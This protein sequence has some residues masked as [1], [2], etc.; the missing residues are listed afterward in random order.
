MRLILLALVV[1]AFPTFANSNTESIAEEEMSAKAWLESM[2]QALQTKQYK[3]SIIQLQADHIRPLVYL[4]GTVNNKEVA[5][6]EYLNGPPKNAVRVADT[7]TFIEHD[8]PA[9]SITAPRIQGVWP[10]IFATDLSSLEEG[11]QFILGGRSR[12]A[13][14][15]GQMIRIMPVDDNRFMSQVWIDMD[16][17]LPLRYD[18]INQDKQ[19]IEQMMVIELLELNEPA[20]ILVEA[21]KQG[22]PP[23]MNPAERIKGQNWEFSWLPA[24]FHMVVKDHHRLIGSDESVE[25]IALSDGL[26]NISVYVARM[27]DSPMP[28]ELIT[29]NGL[30][31]IV[32]QVG[33]VEVVA[34]GKVPAETLNRIAKSLILK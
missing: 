13:G 26:V 33:N 23:V 22:L 32:E 17:R 11:Y 7:V 27:G 1:L 20:K 19:L 25:Y 2:S 6:L 12:I 10:T 24:G 16:T 21:E 14:R 3:S 18:M 15:P 8:Q 34:V 30:S 31:M 29:R 9:Y 5:F 4:H 28:D